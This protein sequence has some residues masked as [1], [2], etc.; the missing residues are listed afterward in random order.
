M[1]L[2]AA[3]PLAPFWYEPKDENGEPCGT[4]FLLCGLKS[5]EL[6]DLYASSL[7]GPG[8]EV[9]FPAAAIRGAMRSGLRGWENLL[10]ENDQPIEFGKSVDGNIDR[11]PFVV[12]S[13][14]IGKVLEA[15][16]L[17]GERAKN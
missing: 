3:S 12:L 2:R 6:A 14:L 7:Q 10:D 13:E 5:M 15:S 9:K 8:G 1:A 17:S 16:A 4:R 11:L